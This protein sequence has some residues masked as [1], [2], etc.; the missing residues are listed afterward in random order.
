[1]AVSY[2]L[3]G[4]RLLVVGASSGLGRELGWLASRSGAR[5]AFA[6]RRAE[7]LQEAAATAAG[8]ALAVP[9]DVTSAADCQRAVAETVKEFGGLDALVYAVGMSPLRTLD[10]AGEAEWRV[11]LETNV[12]GAS[13]ACAAAL[14]HLRESDGRALF[15]SSY[16]VRAVMPGLSLYRVSKVAL[17]A[18]IECWRGEFPEVSFTRVVV[19]NTVGTEFSAGWDPEEFRRTLELWK[20]RNVYPSNTMMSV[21]ACAEAVASVLAVRAY[22]DDIAVMARASDT[23]MPA[24]GP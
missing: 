7:R 15:L 14:P 3:A 17:D 10:R 23:A 24:D 22:V 5:V 12:M 2:D 20:Q 4:L 6:A 8:P 11:V 9:C 13:L 18:L 21:E 1:M 16:S 19:G